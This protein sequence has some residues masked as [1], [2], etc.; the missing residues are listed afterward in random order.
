MTDRNIRLTAF[1]DRAGWAGATCVPLAGDASARRYLRVTDGARRAV[2][3]DAPAEAGEDIGPF[4]RMAHHLSGLDL[5]PPAV[6]AEDREHGFL[7]L[8]DLGDDLFAR[9]V[10]ATP[11]LEPALYASALD[12][13]ERL[14]AGP[15]PDLP[16]YD[17]DTMADAAGLAVDWYADRRDAAERADL[18]RHVHNALS[19]VWS[20]PEVVVLRDYHAENLIWL[21]NRNG[22]RR[23]GL[24]DFQDA[25]LGH[26]VYDA[27]SLL[28]DARRDVGDDTVSSLRDRLA[29]QYPEG[30][31]AFESAFACL[32][33]QRCLRI[34][35]V[36][37]RLCLRDGK[38]GYLALL[39][40]VWGQLDTCLSHPDLAELA[41]VVRESLPPPTQDRIERL[42]M[43]GAS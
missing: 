22:P 3:M 14:Q 2:L 30:A 38:P 15:A 20:V 31:A 28:L 29:G 17:P 12:V 19:Q 26:P 10:K 27:V 37:A 16:R 6:L 43:A 41:D 4:I 36:F 32:G 13:L 11:S 21:P 18:A 33:A 35:G 9:V 40:R 42:R 1:I 34:L 23:V 39:P 7:L 25:M 24:L 5:S 8:E